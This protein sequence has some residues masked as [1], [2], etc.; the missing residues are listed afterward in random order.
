MTCNIE[1]KVILHIGDD[2]VRV[3]RNLVTDS[4]TVELWISRYSWIDYRYDPS[5]PDALRPSS[6]SIHT[7]CYMPFGR[8]C[9]G[10]RYF[11][12]EGAHCMKYKYLYI[13]IHVVNM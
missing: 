7:W 9:S 6:F 2:R 12:S 4:R 5:E 10:N 1:R 8:H 3:Y 11:Q 13:Y